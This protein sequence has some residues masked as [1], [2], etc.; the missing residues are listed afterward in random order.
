MHRLVTS[1]NLGDPTDRAML[2]DA[3]EEAGRIHE[4]ELLRSRDAV[5]ERE[6]E[7][8]PAAIHPQHVEADRPSVQDEV[9]ASY[10]WYDGYGGQ[11]EMALHLQQG[12]YKTPG[13]TVVP[14]YRW[15][16][17][18]DG[19]VGGVVGEGPWLHSED[20]AREDAEAHAQEDANEDV[21]AD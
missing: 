7:L 21:P 9:L 19:W 2:S 11:F 12:E 14:V 1:A 5:R 18:Q 10:D 13:G 16:K 17:F 3:L 6:G 4:A 15:V 20:E 8:V